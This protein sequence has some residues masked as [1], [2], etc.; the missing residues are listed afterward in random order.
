MIRCSNLLVMV[1][2]CAASD[3]PHGGRWRG[4]WP[5]ERKCVTKSR[6]RKNGGRVNAHLHRHHPRHHLAS[7]WC[8][9]QVR[10]QGGILDLSSADPVWVYPRNYLCCLCHYQEL[11]VSLP[12]PHQL[13]KVQI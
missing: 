13:F 1:E 7:P 12:C 10:L 4:V 11:I 9:L 8:L 5:Q 2:E 6:K 3:F